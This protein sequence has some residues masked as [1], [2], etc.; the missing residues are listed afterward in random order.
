MD[1][2][3]LLGAACHVLLSSLHGREHPGRLDDVLGPSVGPLDVLGVALVEDGDLLPVDIEELAV[4]LHLTLE[5]AVSGVV[6]EHVHHVVEGD[7]GIIDSDDL[8]KYDSKKNDNIL[9]F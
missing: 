2:P 4:L 3:H 8:Q 6:L 1:G 9:I 7:E 5:L